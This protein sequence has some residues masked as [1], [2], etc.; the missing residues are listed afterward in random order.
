MITEREASASGEVERGEPDFASALLAWEEQRL[1]PARQRGERKEHFET[2]S[3]IPVA[4]LYTPADLKDHDALRDEGFPGE[5]PFTR[6]IQP[7][8]YRGRLWSIRQYAGFGTAERRERALPLPARAG[9]ARALGGVRPPDPDGPRQRRP[10]QRGRGRPGRRRHRLGARHAGSVRRHPAQRGEHLD[11][12]QR[13]GAGARRDVRR[14]GRTAGPRR[15]RRSWAPSRTTCSRSTSRAAPSSIRR[16]RRC[17]SRPTS[18]RGA[19]S[20]HR[21]STRSRCPG[22]TF[23][24][25]EAPPRR[26]WRSR[27][28]TRARTCRRRSIAAS[29][30]MTSLPSSPGSST[31]TSISSRRSP[32]TAR[33]A[34]CGRASWRSVSVRAIRGR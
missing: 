15:P 19:P 14:R 18:S 29:A 23:A 16:G 9:P 12:H 8:M 20:T 10:A 28:P 21:S 2:G 5:P 25:R 22:I 24:K 3:G 31:R 30:S 26:R 6:G 1:E 7:T 11:D 33:C 32:S 17:V 13:A 4:P 27:S 34:A